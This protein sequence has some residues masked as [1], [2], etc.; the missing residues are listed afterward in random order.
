MSMLA[1]PR[2]QVCDGRAQGSCA[3]LTVFFDG[4]CPLCRREIAFY[5]RRPGA[6]ALRWVDVSAVSGEEVADGLCTRAAMQRFHV[7][8][9]NGELASGARAFAELWAVIPGFRLLG[10]VM[11]WRPLCGL[12]EMLYVQFLKLRPRLQRLAAARDEVA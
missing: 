10:R 3:P 8:M 4:A 2:G 12:L 11:Q 9:D 1:N 5:R 6:E 7:R